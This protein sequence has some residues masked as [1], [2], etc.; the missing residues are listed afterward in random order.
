MS[1]GNTVY[2][3][4]FKQ[5]VEL[6]T[7]YNLV[8]VGEPLRDPDDNRILGYNGVYTGTGHVTR[9]GDPATLI[10]TAVDPRD[11]SRRQAVPGRRRRAA[12]LHA[13][14]ARR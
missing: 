13:E 10:M 9:V 6:G 14:P 3:R 11:L 7:H 8:R 4:G 2:A 12:R 5:P 1:E